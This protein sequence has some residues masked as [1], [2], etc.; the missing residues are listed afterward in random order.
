MPLW[1][2]T[3]QG[4]ARRNALDADVRW[5]RQWVVNR[6]ADIQRG[7]LCEGFDEGGREDFAELVE[8]ASFD[9]ADAFLGDAE[10]L[11]ELLEGLDCASPR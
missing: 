6:S 9:L 3:M 10:P 2:W 1:R 7:L 4:H 8:G 5:H 11:T